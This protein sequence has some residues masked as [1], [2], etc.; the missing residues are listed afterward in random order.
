MAQHLPGESGRLLKHRVS[1]LGPLLVILLGRLLLLLSK[2]GR[3]K[4]GRSWKGGAYF[5]KG[6]DT[7][8]MVMKYPLFDF[9]KGLGKSWRG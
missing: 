9:T 2:E 8:D 1:R 6:V 7:K 3:K 4:R 5:R